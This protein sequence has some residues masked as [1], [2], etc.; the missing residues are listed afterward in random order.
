MNTWMKRE[1][2]VIYPQWHAIEPLKEIILDETSRT[3]KN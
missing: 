2:V 1:N 3:H